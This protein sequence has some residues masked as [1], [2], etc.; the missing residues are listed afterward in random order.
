[1]L[2]VLQALYWAAASVQ[3]DLNIPV[4]WINQDGADARRSSMKQF[5]QGTTNT[6]IPAVGRSD[7]KA[8]QGQVPG[9]T[10]RTLLGSC[11]S[12]GCWKEHQKGFVSETEAA[13]TYSHLTAVA[14]AYEQGCELALIMEDDLQ[15]SNANKTWPH[16]MAEIHDLAAMAPSDWKVLQLMVSNAAVVRWLGEVDDLFVPWTWYHYAAM[17]YLINRQ[18]LAELMQ[19]FY[20]K[21]IVLP[22]AAH[23]RVFTLPTRRFVADELLFHH[24]KSY[25]STRFLFNFATTSSSSSHQDK[26]IVS[27]TVLASTESILR[28]RMRPLVPTHQ[29]HIGTDVLVLTVLR[30]SPTEATPVLT[31]NLRY[32]AHIPQVSWLYHIVLGPAE[33]ESSWAPTIGQAKALVGDRVQ[34][35]VT[36][37]DTHQ[38]DIS[39]WALFHKASR[40]FSLYEYVFLLG[41]A[42]DVTGFPVGE[43]FHRLRH[44]LGTAPVITGAPLH[45]DGGRCPVS[46]PVYDSAWWFVD[47]PQ[48]ASTMLTDWAHPHL[49]VVN[50]EFFT[51][52]LQRLFAGPND[53]NVHNASDD[54]GPAAL[55]CGAAQDFAPGNVSCALIPLPAVCKAQGSP[56][57]HT[58]SA[59]AHRRL[60]AYYARR[61]PRWWEHSRPFRMA[62]N[63]PQGRRL[64]PTDWRSPVPGLSHAPRDPLRVSVMIVTFD[65]PEFLGL[66]LDNI[67]Q[68]DY[69]VHE[70]VIVDDSPEALPRDLPPLGLDQVKYIHLPARTTIGAKRNVACAAAT[71]DVLVHWDDDDYFHSSRLRVQVAP[72]QEGLANV[73]VLTMTH[74]LVLPKAAFYTAVQFGP[75]Y[76]T[77]A[78]RRSVWQVGD[79]QFHNVS[80][81]E[82]AMFLLHALG[83]CHAVLTLPSPVAVYARHGANAL[84]WPEHIYAEE[85]P[86]AGSSRP[87]WFPESVLDRYM[88]AAEVPPPPHPFAHVPVSLFG[89][90]RDVPL[91]PCGNRGVEGGGRHATRCHISIPPRA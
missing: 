91:Y 82:D 24:T 45:T 54:T 76:G 9:F 5:L 57:T 1:M 64:S 35:A 63:G 16:I 86:M 13:I 90:H 26:R 19:T 38:R 11:S 66:A 79:L 43:F 33:T 20:L 40:L 83:Q 47:H 23:L 77:L 48:P 17:V 88:A 89:F 41:S 32:L 42:V 12:E 21:D 58:S 3:N 53:A 34:F 85:G 87:P 80:F 25:T 29:Q 60:T 78:Y 50:G 56:S 72:L 73:T 61:F 52:F 27:Q 36:R 15:F 69:P 8:V 68:Q 74:V 71:G 18:G 2:L 65:R 51:W 55:W 7:I 10:N 4:F 39:D 75:H 49:A 84:S 14:T 59:T 44:D 22:T 30:S 28:N 81:A 37:L 6:R 62:F 70:V 31:G 67:L 46:E